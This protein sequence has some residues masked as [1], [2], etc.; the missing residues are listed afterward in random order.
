MLFL[1]TVGEATKNCKIINVQFKITFLS[2]ISP[3]TLDFPDVTQE[4]CMIGMF[5]VID[6]ETCFS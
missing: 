1:L 5:V 3:S 6:A 4:F 2:I